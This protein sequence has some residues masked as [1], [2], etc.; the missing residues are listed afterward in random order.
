MGGERIPVP[1]VAPPTPLVAP[2]PPKEAPA[3]HLGGQLPAL[4]LVPGFFPLQLILATPQRHTLLLQCPLQPAGKG[5]GGDF[6]WGMGGD[7]SRF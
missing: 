1:P 2:P 7:P 6:F 5:C 4:A 3:T